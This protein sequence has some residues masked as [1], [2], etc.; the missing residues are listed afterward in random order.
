MT[1]CVGTE[2]FSITEDDVLL[3]TNG[4]NKSHYD[5]NLFCHVT[6][7]QATIHNSFL[8]IYRDSISLSRKGT[9]PVYFLSCMAQPSQ[10]DQCLQNRI[11]RERVDKKV[12][13]TN[14]DEKN[15]SITESY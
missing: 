12:K 2:S 8:K 15:V 9:M 11:K 5:K 3:K 10:T 1:A 4:W 14:T 13:T 6:Q 7:R